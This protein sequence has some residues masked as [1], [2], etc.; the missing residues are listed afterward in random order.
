MAAPAQAA[1]DSASRTKPR[2]KAKR[3]ETA[4]IPM[5]MMSSVFIGAS[6]SLWRSSSGSPRLDAAGDVPAV[7]AGRVEQLDQLLQLA[8]FLHL[9]RRERHL[10][11]APLRAR[12]N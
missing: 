8:D 3:P 10:D 6:R 4:M 9:D 11:L 5:T 7:E 1:M 12:R 2:T